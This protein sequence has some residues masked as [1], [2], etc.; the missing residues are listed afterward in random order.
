MKQRSASNSCHPSRST[1]PTLLKGCA[2][3][4]PQSLLLAAQTDSFPI[5]LFTTRCQEVLSEAYSDVRHLSSLVACM[6]TTVSYLEVRDGTVLSPSVY[7]ML[8]PIAHV[9]SDQA[10][11]TRVMVRRGLHPAVAPL[12]S[13]CLTAGP[14][15]LACAGGGLNRLLGPPSTAV[16]TAT[17]CDRVVTLRPRARRHRGGN[18]LR[19]CQPHAVAAPVE[20]LGR[21]MHL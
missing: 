12:P 19:S 11:Y 15:T 6:R 17:G 14:H 7:R 4:A 2:A 9:F 18:G 21:S 8:I 20:A 1:I 13:K 16:P 10:K 3:D 5:H